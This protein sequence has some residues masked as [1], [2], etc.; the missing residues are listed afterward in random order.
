MARPRM[1]I[2]QALQGIVESAGKTIADVGC[3]DGALVRHF[4]RAG[5]RAIGIE[6]SEGQLARARAQAGQGETYMV[7][8]GESLPF[9]NASVDAILYMKSFHHL[10]MPAMPA[11]LIEAARVL[12][13]EG[14]LVAIEPLPEGTFFQMTRLVEDET[15]VRA[16]AYA[17]LTSPPS[18]L[19]PER[20]FFYDSAVRVPNAE[21]VLEMM[22]AVD[23]ARRERVAKAEPEIRRRFDAL[24]QE[25]PDGPFFIA[26]MRCNVLVRAAS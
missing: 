6:V 1:T 11:A 7:A 9:P 17:A 16:A 19:I 24:V 4:A 2:I 8:S 26:P 10:P 23:P 15:E 12:A 20:E 14:L 22:A 13:P 5:A 18:S 25:D 3:G 21:R